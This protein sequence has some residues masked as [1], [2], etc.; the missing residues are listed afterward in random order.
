MSSKASHCTKYTVHRV[1][2]VKR[3][4]IPLDDCFSFLSVRKRGKTIIMCNQLEAL[5]YFSQYLFQ[6]NSIYLGFFLT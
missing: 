1:H 2:I 3:N 4:M 5:L 6:N